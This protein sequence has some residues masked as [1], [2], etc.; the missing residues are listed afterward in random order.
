[1]AIT[2]RTEA[3]PENIG[4]SQVS[5]IYQVGETA[6]FTLPDNIL[7]EV[8]GTL[9]NNMLNVGVINLIQPANTIW[10]TRFKRFFD[11][12]TESEWSNPERVFGSDL[13]NNRF[14]KFDSIINRPSIKVKLDNTGMNIAVSDA[15]ITGGDGHLYNTYLLY[16]NGEIIYSDTENTEDLTGIFIPVSTLNFRLFN[17]ITVM[18]IQGTANGAESAIASTVVANS[19]LSFMITG[20]FIDIPYNRGQR[21]ELT[22]ET[23]SIVVSDAR[24]YVGS[25]DDLGEMSRLVFAN[26]TDNLTRYSEIIL[27]SSIL[28]PS[29]IYTLRLTLSSTLDNSILETFDYIITTDKIDSSF[30]VDRDYVYRE[31]ITARFTSTSGILPISNEEPDYTMCYASDYKDIL[32]S[33]NSFP[34][35]LSV[36]KFYPNNSALAIEKDIEL[37]IL[38]DSGKKIVFFTR[39]RNVIIVAAD[40]DVELKVIKC[41]YNPF[42]NR[43]LVKEST[44]YYNTTNAR[45]IVERNSVALNNQ[46]THLYFLEKTKLGSE[47]ARINL[48]DMSKEILRE[49]PK[50]T[51][52]TTLVILDD[53]KILSVRGSDDTT[54][55][56]IY[57][58]RENLWSPYTANFPADPK[59]LNCFNGVLRKDGKV[60]I[61]AAKNSTANSFLVLDVEEKQY[62]EETIDISDDYTLD[63]IIRQTD[64]SFIL[65]TSNAYDK[66]D[67]TICY[68]Y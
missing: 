47:F 24:I 67:K 59:Y 58:I 64:G 49:R 20:M 50:M 28:E 36:F 8:E 41:S 10:W 43:K 14:V 4:K 13:N 11:D 29:N 48:A 21:Y 60:A 56:F 2:I 61:F 19:R 32:L 3:Y 26:N 63:N 33:S 66:T 45:S 22:S 9:L 34:N 40:R 53:D 25:G 15:L 16:S 1:M 65:V 6:D 30:V 52:P 46:E 38:D 68:L 35:S 18:V 17:N 31:K 51:G 27:N 57:S 37:D 55:F 5:T 12:S 39:D 62:T 54:D 44:M 7:A 23:N 42:D